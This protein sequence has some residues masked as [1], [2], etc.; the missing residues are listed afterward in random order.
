MQV[1][2]ALPTELQSEQIAG[3]IARCLSAPMIITLSGVIG[4]GKTTL[5]RALLRSLGILS[6]IKSPTFSLVESYECA[7]M[8][9]HHFDL[10]RIQ[11]E[12]EL[13]YIGFR[14]YFTN[15]SVCCIEWPE[16]SINYLESVDLAC[17]LVRKGMGREMTMCAYSPSAKQLLSC[18]A[19]EL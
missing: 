13:D 6:A 5:V 8:P 14:D 10:Y 12:S 2:I 11:D 4:S 17:S 1:T 15:N 19:G 9:F 3:R 16:R 18:L 7:A